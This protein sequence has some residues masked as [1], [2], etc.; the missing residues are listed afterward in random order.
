P[1]FAAF[2]LLKDAAGASALRKYFDSYVALA[3]QYGIG[4]V[5]ES[6]TW[7]ANP[8]WGAKLGYS[9]EALVDANRRAIAL[10]H[11]VRARHESPVTP[12]VVSGCIGPRGDGYN[13]ESFMSAAE[14]ERYHGMQATTFRD[15]GADMVT[16]ITMT[17]P[18]EAVGLTRA[19]RA[20]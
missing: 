16:A 10:L 7:R 17:Y 3:E 2:D 6:P 1:C 9:A 5:L 8:D 15:A 13:P 14:A 19:A 12:I 11:E 18:N 20:A 4:C